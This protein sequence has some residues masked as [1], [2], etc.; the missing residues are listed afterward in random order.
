VEIE[1]ALLRPG[2]AGEV[3]RQAL[4]PVQVVGEGGEHCLV[5]DEDAVGHAL[6][7]GA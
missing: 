2:Q 1:G 3:A 6:D 4:Q 7:L 5:G